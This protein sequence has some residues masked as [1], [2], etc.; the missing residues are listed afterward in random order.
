MFYGQHIIDIKEQKTISLPETFAKELQTNIF[1]TQGFEQNLMLMPESAFINL[2]HRVLNM[3]LANPT[4]RFFLRHFLANATFIPQAQLN[5]IQIPRQLCDY[6]DFPDETSA[7]IVGQG[8][9][10]EIWGQ[11]KWQQQNEAL[12]KFIRK[13]RTVFNSGSSEQLRG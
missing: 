8:E 11:K 4:V 6:A 1:V 12:Q 9:H 13:Q 2:Y 3:N 5:F 7:V 10:I